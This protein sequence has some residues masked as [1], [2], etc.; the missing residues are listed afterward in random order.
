MTQNK[1]G[2]YIFLFIVLL[3]LLL[4]VI[5]QKENLID[6]LHEIAQSTKEDNYDKNEYAPTSIPDRNH[7]DIAQGDAIIINSARCTV[8]YIDTRKSTIYTAG[9]CANSVGEVVYNDKWEEIG[10]VVQDNLLD[11][12]GNYWLEPHDSSAILLHDTNSKLVNRFSE[13]AVLQS[14]DVHNKDT[15]CSYG[16]TTKRVYCGEIK[17]IQDGFFMFTLDGKPQGGDSG[18]PVWIPGRGLLG[19][20]SGVEK[21][22][23]YTASAIVTK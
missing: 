3:C 10:T 12:N 2:V 18:G 4:L 11:H 7:A 22:K 21:G 19:V 16:S 8:G 5:L 17:K 1:K 20:L 13:D 9:H 14:S 23:Y 6:T 15:V